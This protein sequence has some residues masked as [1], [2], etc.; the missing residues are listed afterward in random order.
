LAVPSGLGIL[1]A[2]AG[3]SGRFCAGDESFMG[4]MWPDTKITQA[5]SNNSISIGF[6]RNRMEVGFVRS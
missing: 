2:G 5:A 4:K 6:R 1:G 3:E